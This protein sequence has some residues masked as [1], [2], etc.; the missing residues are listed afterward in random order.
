MTFEN[1]AILEKRISNLTE[2]FNQ[3]VKNRA[4]LIQ[5]IKRLT[6]QLAI[7]EKELIEMKDV[8]SDK[9]TIEQNNKKF[10]EENEKIKVKTKNI[11]ESLEQLELLLDEESDSVI[12]N[13]EH[14][15]VGHEKNEEI[16]ETVSEEI[17]LTPPVSDTNRKKETDISDKSQHHSSEAIQLTIDTE[18]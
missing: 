3:L 12:S 10:I 4:V 16:K 6:E 14:E 9:A 8:L 15:T 11:L 2:K 18:D 7:R 1:L 5:K 13:I 17:S